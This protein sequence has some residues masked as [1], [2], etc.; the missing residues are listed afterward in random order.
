MKSPSSE[1]DHDLD[2]PLAAVAAAVER[3]HGTRGNTLEEPWADT[4]TPAGRMVL[5][6]FAGVAEHERE[7]ISQR[8]RAALQVAR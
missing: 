1:R 7:M 4:T 6:V 3:A 2:E 5:T 8:T